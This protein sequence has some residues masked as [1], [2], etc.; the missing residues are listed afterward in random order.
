M[1]SE[2]DQYQGMKHY[3]TP[4]KYHVRD[5]VYFSDY[6][7]RNRRETRQGVVIWDIS[8]RNHD[9]IKAAKHRIRKNKS[10]ATTTIISTAI[11]LGS[12]EII[13]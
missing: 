13:P 2:K 7:I 5:F 11:T 1:Q 3:I 10:I 6:Y 8:V 12:N 4:I 9:R